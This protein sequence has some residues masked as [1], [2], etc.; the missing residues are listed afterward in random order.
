VIVAVAFVRV[1]QMTGDE[2]VDV[3]TVWNGLVT[4]ALAVNVAAVVLGAVMFGR[5][6]VRVLAVDLE[7]VLVDVTLVRMVQVPFVQV[8]HVVTVRDARMTTIVAVLVWMV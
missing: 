2:V 7:H 3:I 5:A 6:A 8:V 1:M 4:A